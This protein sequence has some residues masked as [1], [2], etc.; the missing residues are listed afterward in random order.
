MTNLYLTFSTSAKELA[1]QITE[2][3]SMEEIEDLIVALDESAQDM[4]FTENVLK[5]IFKSVLPC[6]DSVEEY[7]EFVSSFMVKV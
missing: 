6:F 5:K 7:N 1:Y 4:D 2:S 3:S